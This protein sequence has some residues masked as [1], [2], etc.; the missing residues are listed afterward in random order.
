M[1]RRRLDNDNMAFKKHKNDSGLLEYGDLVNCTGSLKCGVGTR[2]DT[3]GNTYNRQWIRGRINGVG[4]M[5]YSNGSSYQ[6]QWCDGLREG[7]GT[8]VYPD[9]SC[10]Q[11]QWVRGRIEGQGCR[12]NS[13][14]KL[15]AKGTWKGDILVFGFKN[16]YLDNGTVVKYDHNNQLIPEYGDIAALHDK[17]KDMATRIDMLQDR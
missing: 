7:E 13:K 6:G 1:I 8:M 4:T 16:M 3:S 10:Y 17:I 15:L 5:I 11:G 14:G 2:T 12:R 9:G